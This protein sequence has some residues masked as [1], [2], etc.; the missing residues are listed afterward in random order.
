[1]NGEYN[2]ASEDISSPPIITREEWEDAAARYKA[3]KEPEWPCVVEYQAGEANHVHE[4][5][6]DDDSDVEGSET[7][8]D[9]GDSNDVRAC[10]ACAHFIKLRRFT[11][12]DFEDLTDEQWKMFHHLV[13]DFLQ[14]VKDG[15]WDG[16]TYGD[17]SMDED[18]ED[19]EDMDEDEPLSPVKGV[20]YDSTELRR[21]RR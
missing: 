10:V 15:E 8:S 5:A 2:H 6:M 17:D 3:S 7:S 14:D 1:M 21:T 4:W 9:L 19:E 11:V 16:I 13:G 12:E 20:N 18:E